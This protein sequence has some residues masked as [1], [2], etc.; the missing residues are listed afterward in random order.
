MLVAAAQAKADEYKR[1]LDTLKTTAA[2]GLRLA[3][4]NAKLQ[5]YI[6]PIYCDGDR[7]GPR[8]WPFIC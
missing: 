8:C 6:P 3:I 2:Y 4:A 7:W 5:R 1:E